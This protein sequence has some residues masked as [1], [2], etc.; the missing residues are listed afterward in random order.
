MRSS[1]E[2]S[3]HETR[4]VDSIP[5]YEMDCMLQSNRYIG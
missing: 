2:G 4:T 3:V 5:F 1:D